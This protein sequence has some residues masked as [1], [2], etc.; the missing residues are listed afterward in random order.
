MAKTAA[1]LYQRAGY[2]TNSQRLMGRQAASEGFLKAMSQYGTAESLYCYTR[3]RQEFE[4][5][6]QQVRPWL[7]KGRSLRWVSSENPIALAEPGVLYRPDPMLSQLAW[8]RRYRHQSA[9]SLCGITHTLASKEVMTGLGDLLIA[10]IQPWDAVICTSIAVKTLVERLL[11]DWADYLAQ[12]VG[13]RPKIDFKLPVIPLGIDSAAFLQG[14][15]AQDARQ[16][17]RQQLGIAADELVVLF[18]GRLIFHAKAH[19]LPMYL[20]IEQAAQATTTKVHLVQAGWFEDPQQEAAFKQAAATFCP[21]VNAVF[22]DG[23]QPEIRQSIWSAADVFISLADNIQETFGLTPIEAMAAGLPVIVTDWD[24]YQETVRHEVDGF[25]IPTTLPPAGCSGDFA[26]NYFEDTLNYSTYVGH[27]SLITAVDIEACTQALTALF[28]QPELRQQ[29][30]A[31]GRQRARE[32]Y[33]WQVVMR[34]YE[35]LWQEQAELQTAATVTAPVAAG[36]PAQPLCDDPCRLYAHYP[37]QQLSGHQVLA[38][39]AMATPDRLQQLRDTWMVNFGADRRSSPGVIDQVIA[40]IAQ[41]G[42]LTVAEIVQ[43]WGGTDPASRIR[44]IRTLVYLL[45]FNVL[46]PVK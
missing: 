13:A 39:G 19:P 18:V 42:S 26:A 1:I 14:Q 35:T 36:Q 25:R 30:G 33:D 5:F 34:S 15:A 27:I 37:T 8:Q 32:V 28:T 2:D 11:H 12:R 38:L 31:N 24:G 7:A 20:A 45:K 29:M 6:C 43:Q 40:A 9:Y 17:L 21:S 3:T 44:L 41:A 16:Q 4:E 23:R 22:V 10:P 46:Q